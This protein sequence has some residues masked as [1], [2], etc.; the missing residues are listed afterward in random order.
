MSTDPADFVAPSE[1]RPRV[2]GRPLVHSDADLERLSVITE[3]DKDAAV[4]SWKRL[5]PWPYKG[6]V[7]AATDGEDGIPSEPPGA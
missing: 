1:P 2:R 5:A 7:D 4:E 3:A 6:L